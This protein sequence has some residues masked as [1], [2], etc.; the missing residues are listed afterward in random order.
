MLLKKNVLY[1]GRRNKID[2]SVIRNVLV[3]VIH[4]LPPHYIGLYA[5]SVGTTS[6]G[7]LNGQPSQSTA[8]PWFFFCFSLKRSFIIVF[9][10]IDG[11][12]CSLNKSRRIRRVFFILGHCDLATLDGHILTTFFLF[13]R[14]SMFIPFKCYL[15]L[16][17]E[18]L[19]FFWQLFVLLPFCCFL[20]RYNIQLCQLRLLLQKSY[21]DLGHFA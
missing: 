7:T 14:F 15:C 3:G 12:L 20:I 18:I 6:L 5:A 16:L 4:E 11:S 13:I 8:I 2:S 9:S 17:Q 19:M 10:V 1:Q 21:H